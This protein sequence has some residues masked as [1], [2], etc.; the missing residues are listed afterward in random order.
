MKKIT[1]FSPALFFENN[2]WHTL[3][4]GD[5]LHVF[6]KT[7]KSINLTNITAIKTP[8]NNKNILY[9][10]FYACKKDNPDICGVSIEIEKHIPLFSGLSAAQSQSDTFKQYLENTTN[11]I[12]IPK[13]AIALFFPKNITLCEKPKNI[14]YQYPDLQHIENILQ[15]EN[16]NY[17]RRDDRTTYV[18]K[19]PQNI[20]KKT[21]TSLEKYGVFVFCS[22]TGKYIK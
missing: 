22:I 18:I 15:T 4:F 3:D 7:S 17:S 5:F 11:I 8:C 20:L 16:I 12:Q 14:F 13:Q 1:L 21:Q 2:I 9:K 6:E 19:N 10:T